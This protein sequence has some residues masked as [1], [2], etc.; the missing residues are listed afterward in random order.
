LACHW[1]QAS[2]IHNHPK[3]YYGT[4]AAQTLRPLCTERSPIPN[5]TNANAIAA[6]ATAT[7]PFW[8]TRAAALV[9]FAVAPLA[10]AE[11]LVDVAVVVGFAD[12]EALDEPDEVGADDD[13]AED[14]LEDD[15]GDDPEDA[16]EDE[17]GA[18][19]EAQTADWGKFVTPTAL[20]I[21]FAN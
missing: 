4:T 6:A 18:A 19:L 16:C 9:G 15:P 13:A 21:P 10:A 7:P 1:F 17:L 14:D 5:Y 12:E 2:N 8:T 20:Q 3:P 11:E